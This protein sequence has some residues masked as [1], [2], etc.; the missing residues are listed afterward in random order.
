MFQWLSAFVDW[1]PSLSIGRIPADLTGNDRIQGTVEFA[2]VA[3]VLVTNIILMAP[4]VF[5]LRRWRL[6]FGSVTFL[7]GAVAGMMSGLSE[8]DRW[9]TIVAALAGGL[10]CDS[11][12]VWLEITGTRPFA[13]RVTA[14]ITPIVLW[15]AYFV[16]LPTIHDVHWPLDLWLGTVGLAAVTGVL[17]S[18][19]AVAP[20]PPK[21]WGDAPWHG[22]LGRPRD[23]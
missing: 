1:A 23:R 17:L 18:F 13:Y 2:D 10:A 16:V 20:A 3:R 4:V 21:V 5:A 14:G 11:L 19:V 9:G 12:V 7:F 22:P 15:T 6:P 8:Y